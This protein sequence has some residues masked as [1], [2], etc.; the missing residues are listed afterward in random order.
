MFEDLKSNLEREEKIVADMKVV[1]SAIVGD[2]ANKDFYNKTL[3]SLVSQLKILNDVVPGLLNEWNVSGQGV[4]NVKASV[5][6][7]KVSVKVDSGLM[8]NKD[9]EMVVLKGGDKKKYLDKLKMSEEALKGLRKLEKKKVGVGVKEPN[10]YAM[11]SSRFFGGISESLI[12]RFSNVGQDLKRSNIRFLLSVYLAMA[13]MSGMIAF[14]VGFSVLLISIFFGFFSLAIVALPFVLSGIVFAG[15]YFYPASETGTLQK[16]ISYELPFA[17]IHMAAIAG[18]DVEPV[19]IFKIIGGSDEYP[20]I[21]AELRKVI[22]QI[23][24]Y[25]YDLVTALKNVS[26][27]IANKALS[28]LFSGLATNISSGGALK[29]YL[30]EK[31]ESFLVDYRLERQRYTALAGTF[32]DVYI[33]ILIAAPLIL[34]MMFIV[35]NVSGLSM[36]GISIEV[37]LLLSVFAIVLVNIL[38]LFIINI[39]QPRV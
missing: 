7:K 19:N 8:G 39:K 26:S 14:G 31:S 27:K 30:R 35:M 10:W 5:G 16:Q 9:K 18:S 24:V 17:T 11:L 6:S 15:F 23:E 38:F 22:M 37:L 34:M 25:G 21:G 12:P 4:A 13:L 3:D 2:S 20:A 1:T 32:M 36:G 28:E 29:N 33:S